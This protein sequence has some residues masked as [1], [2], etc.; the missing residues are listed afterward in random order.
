MI[1]FLNSLV[2]QRQ[3][4]WTFAKN[5]IK[6][7]YLGSSLGAVWIFVLPLI[8]LFIIW[9]AFEHGLKTG[10]QGGVPFILWLI[11][12]MFP[13]TFF[14]DA[15]AS[16]TNSIAEKSF[17][18][19]KVLF[20]VELLPFIKIVASSVLFCFL[21]GVMVVFF[22][23]YRV[24]PDRYWMQ[25]PYFM[26]C[27]FS[28]VMSLSWLTSA[29]V[30]F[31]KDLGQLIAV[32]LQIGFWVTPIFWS[33][34]KLPAN[35]QFVTFLN[36]VNYVVSGYRDSFINKAWFWENPWQTLYFWSFV[37]FFSTLGLAVFKKLRPH[38]ADV[39]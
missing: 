5:D 36:P 19:K 10:N 26:V 34:E 22:L 8:N 30:V 6:S 17:L 28:L 18:V 33:S 14:A 11:T 1:R 2:K 15:I 24:F 23:L 38:F 29:I 4:V 31:Y 39:L 37:L 13:W 12:G 32:G 25:I 27:I 3:L 9:F 20:N 16:A 35:L 7:R 21:S